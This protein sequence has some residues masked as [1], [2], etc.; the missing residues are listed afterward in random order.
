MN[1]TVPDLHDALL[2]HASLRAGN[3]TVLVDRP[4][5]L[6]AHLAA[7]DGEWVIKVASQADAFDAE[8][9]AMSAL[10]AID[11]PV[12][13]VVFV[14]A[15]PPAVLIASWAPGSPITATH[16]ASVLMEMGR[17]LRRIHSCPASAPY[18]GHPTI[19]SWITAWMA[20]LI[21]WWQTQG[22]SEEER[23]A[24]IWWEEEVGPALVDRAGSQMLFD[25]RPDHMLVDAEGRLHL[26]DV[27]DL[28]A[29][30]PV[31]DLA[32]LELNAPGI[33]EGLLRGYAPSSTERELI[34]TLV[35]FY[36]TLRALSAAEWLANI[37]GEPELVAGYL[38]FVRQQVSIRLRQP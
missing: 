34:T 19:S 11:I 7:A 23:A 14:D 2:R 24:L 20:F 32:V 25:G 38:E 30:D 18:S 10:A 17:L 28:Q 27:A 6:V 31:M 5:R 1:S 33:L 12:S 9:A 36:A 4:D 21:P 37:G 26:I 22:A 8:V 15:G 35:P 29:G 16:P 3:A 13:T